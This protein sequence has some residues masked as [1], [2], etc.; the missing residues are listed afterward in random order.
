MKKVKILFAA[1]A[2]VAVAAGA[3]ASKATETDKIF[4]E[5]AN[6]QCT[7]S[8]NNTLQPNGPVLF[9]TSASIISTTAPCPEVVNVYSPL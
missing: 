4:V 6:H 7:V 5:D 9:R 3:F 2:V 8:L 1:I